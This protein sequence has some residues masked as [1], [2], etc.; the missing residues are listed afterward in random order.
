MW[1]IGIVCVL[2]I[3]LNIY[4]HTHTQWCSTFILS[5][6]PEQFVIYQPQ[7][8]VP[9]NHTQYTAFRFINSPPRCTFIHKVSCIYEMIHQV[10]LPP[11]LHRLIICF[12]KSWFLEFLS[13][14]KDHIF[15]NLDF[16]CLYECTK[17][18]FF[19]I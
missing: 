11:S 8:R 19:Q 15:K 17:F 16:F 10:R 2:Y 13:L 12:I 7:N 6:L 4:K 1:V 14:H 3:I 5:V 9:E 18:F